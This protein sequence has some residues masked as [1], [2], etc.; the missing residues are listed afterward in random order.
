MADVTDELLMAYV[1]GE[2]DETRRS[3]L[4]DQLARDAALAGRLTAQR[5]LRSALA[6]A[7]AGVLSEP[8]PERLLALIAQDGA[9]V[10]AIDGARR[11]PPMGWTWPSA[12]AAC[13]ILGLAVGWVAHSQGPTP[14]IGG[15]PGEMIAQGPLASALDHQLA[16]DEPS[17]AQVKI[18]V[19]FRSADK[20]DCRTFRIDR[21]SGLAGLACRG[22]QAWRIH[23]AIAA[24]PSSPDGARYRTAA[25]DIPPVLA[26]TVEEMIV[27]APFD[28]GAEAQ[29][30][31]RGWRN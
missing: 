17:D 12:I 28:A 20:L 18:G 6:A 24:P 14:L 8:P 30:R 15:A 29:A 10:V 1:D 13:A 27:G 22:P 7:H 3:A 16:S 21:G 11:R 26:S 19:S 9:N 2:L 25:S 31:S 4:E 23:V 5:R